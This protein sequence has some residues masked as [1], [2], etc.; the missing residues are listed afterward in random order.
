MAGAR[1][2]RWVG[3]VHRQLCPLEFSCPKTTD[4]KIPPLKCTD[5]FCFECE[6]VQIPE[7]GSQQF[8][9]AIRDVQKRLS[10]VHPHT[11]TVHPQHVLCTTWISH[12]PH[13]MLLYLYA[14]WLT[15][16]T[17][18]RTWQYCR[19][20]FWVPQCPLMQD[21]TCV[22]SI[23]TAVSGTGLASAFYDVVVGLSPAD[24]PLH[25][26]DSTLPPGS[27]WF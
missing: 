4:C 7:Y 27:T 6:C 17:C 21:V 16:A 8:S 10:F 15:E 3:W 20:P 25:W 19:I 18:Y 22:S 14:A 13:A 24:S 2:K 12:P 23:H 1:V 11:Y 26:W 5:D 9:I